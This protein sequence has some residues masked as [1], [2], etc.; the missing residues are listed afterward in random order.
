MKHLIADLPIGI[1]GKV[2]VQ[3][4]HKSGLILHEHEQENLILD[5]GW[6]T[7]WAARAGF[8]FRTCTPMSP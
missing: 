7:A 2:K 5:A 1:K 8:C 6:T 4:I 3:L